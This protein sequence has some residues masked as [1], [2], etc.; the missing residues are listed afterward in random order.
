MNSKCPYTFTVL[1][2]LAALWSCEERFTPE[3]INI[4]E[5]VVEGYIEAGEQASPPYVILTR[6]MPFFSTFNADGLEGMFVHNATIEI[7][8]GE[9]SVLLTE[10]CLEE[11]NEGQKQL[12]QSFFGFNL[13]SIGFNFCVYIDLSFTM[14]GE[15][16]KTYDLYVE[17]EGIQL[18]ASTYIPEHIAVEEFRFREPPGTPNDTLAQLI[19][20]LN[21]PPNEANYYRYQVD[22]NGTGYISPLA[23]VSD[24]RLFDGELAEFPLAKPEPRGTDDFD[25]ETFGLFRLGDT[26]TI[27]WISL[28][29]AHYNF[30]NTLE[31]SLANQGPFSNYTRIDSN[32]EGGLG[33]WGGISASY[34]RLP[35]ER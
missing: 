3:S 23:S 16:G 12:A 34:Y 1:I 2:F 18:N 30:W 13:D 14:M 11:L 33:I 21:D 22:F 32:V 24:D 27:K 7:S 31:F 8:D 15:E 35:V 5:L 20:T 25:L 29:E 19:C 10:I 4:P 28:D 26:V 6:D 17:S 9:T